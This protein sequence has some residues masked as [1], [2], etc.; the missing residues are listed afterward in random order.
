MAGRIAICVLLIRRCQLIVLMSA[1]LAVVISTGLLG[2]LPRIVTP[3]R[4]FASLPRTGEASV[5]ELRIAFFGS[6]EGCRNCILLDVPQGKRRIALFV[7]PEPDCRIKRSEIG[8]EAFESGDDEVSLTLEFRPHV[9]RQVNSCL[10]VRPNTSSYD[11]VA[12][13]DGDFVGFGF[14]SKRTPDLTLYGGEPLHRL[15]AERAE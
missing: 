10:R 12:T 9:H 8:M 14:Y 1:L 7:R 5:L 13:V 15:W 11:V 3:T 4:G 2:C 6:V